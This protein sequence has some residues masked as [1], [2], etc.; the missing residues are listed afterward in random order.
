MWGV[1]PES[2]GKRQPQ[3]LRTGR[4]YVSS[5][6]GSEHRAKQEGFIEW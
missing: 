2:K 1:V 6:K 4:L 5:E 3:K